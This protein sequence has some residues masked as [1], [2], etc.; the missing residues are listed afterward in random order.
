MNVPHSQEG[1]AAPILRNSW[2]S[3]SKRTFSSP[4]ASQ[5]PPKVSPSDGL[6]SRRGLGTH[7]CA[8]SS[9]LKTW[10]ALSWKTIPPGWSKS[11]PGTSQPFTATQSQT[12][13]DSPRP[14]HNHLVWLAWPSIWGHFNASLT[15]YGSGFCRC[16]SSLFH[17]RG[18]PQHCLIKSPPFASPGQ[19]HSR[20]DSRCFG[21]GSGVF[22]FL[23]LKAIVFVFKS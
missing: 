22:F 19:D 2:L 5:C 13:R 15:S 8:R 14:S 6:I 4:G 7:R 20:K 18:H 1:R 3:T 10:V 17:E 11:T 12:T 21:G 16:A 9:G 23:S